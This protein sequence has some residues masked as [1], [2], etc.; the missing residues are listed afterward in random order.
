M[1][2]LLF[3]VE[4]PP[5][6]AL[7]TAPGY[8]YEWQGFASGASTILKPLKGTKQLQLNA[9]LLNAENSLPAIVELSAL[10]IRHKLAY[11]ALLIP[12]G[13]IALTPDGKLKS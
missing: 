10:A 6:E 7:S 4:V 8:S 5:S 13:A 11:S 9:W 1:P 2:Q 3:V 12:D